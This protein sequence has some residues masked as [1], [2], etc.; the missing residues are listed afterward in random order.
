LFFLKELGEARPPDLKKRGSGT[1]DGIFHALSFD[2]IDDL[3]K[4]SQRGCLDCERRTV[5]AG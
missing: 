2:S 1:V 5:T 3:A 4:A